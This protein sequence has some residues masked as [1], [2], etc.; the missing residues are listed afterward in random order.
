MSDLVAFTR[1]AYGSIRV[2]RPVLVNRV[3]AVVQAVFEASLGQISGFRSGRLEN[4]PILCTLN[5]TTTFKVSEQEKSASRK[6]QRAGEIV[7]LAKDGDLTAR[8]MKAAKET[9][10]KNLL[11]VI[12]VKPGEVSEAGNVEDGGVEERK[13]ARKLCLNL[14]VLSVRKWDGR[15]LRVGTL[16]PIH[17]DLVVPPSQIDFACVVQE[18]EGSL[19]YEVKATVSFSYPTRRSPV[20]GHA[21]RTSLSSHLFRW[22]YVN[23]VSRS[24]TTWHRQPKIRRSSHCP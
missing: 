12:D 5:T 21:S 15:P 18:P 22:L 24:L 14:L 19:R 20:G 13:R 4:K 7:K 9:N 6:S 10:A 3:K 23:V 11:E 16:V 2:G 1:K 8:T 17:A